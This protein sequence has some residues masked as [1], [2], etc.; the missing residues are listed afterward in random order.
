MI[1]DSIP[2]PWI[3][4]GVGV[5]LIQRARATED[6]ADPF[7]ATG[8]RIIMRT[9]TSA[10][11]QK[12]KVK[13]GESRLGSHYGPDGACLAAQASGVWAPGCRGPWW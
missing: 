9:V 5:E 6:D 3:G 8:Q 2:S 1:C 4:V 7:V 11:R 10:I 12:R 13:S